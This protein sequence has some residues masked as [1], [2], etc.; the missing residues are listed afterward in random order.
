MTF[1]QNAS[2]T[3]KWI[4]QNSISYENSFLSDIFYE[5][6]RE[7]SNLKCF[8]NCMALFE[9]KSES[10]TNNF[11]LLSRIFLQK[12]K[13]QVSCLAAYTFIKLTHTHTHTHTHNV[14]FGCGCVL[15]GFLSY[16]K[17]HK[18]ALNATKSKHGSQ[19]SG[20]TSKWKKNKHILEWQ[21]VWI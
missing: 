14:C 11:L 3:F 17:K 2:Q 20:F 9:C 19:K 12:C 8:C 13:C 5:C 10:F 1:A 6:L 16:A 18:P 7:L 4:Y 15:V 21:N